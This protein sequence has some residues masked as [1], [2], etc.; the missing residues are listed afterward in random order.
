MSQGQIHWPGDE[1]KPRGTAISNLQWKSMSMYSPV[2]KISGPVGIITAM[3]VTKR[4]LQRQNL[5]YTILINTSKI[6]WQLSVISP[7]GATR[8]LL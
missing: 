4:Y 1:V 2:I 8:V 7:V 5:R 3:G 6:L